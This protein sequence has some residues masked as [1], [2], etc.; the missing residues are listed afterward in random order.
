MNIFDG[1]ILGVIQGLTEFLPV[2]SSGHL[3]LAQELLNVNPPGALI[4]IVLHI[5]TFFSILVFYRVELWELITGFLNRQCEALSLVVNILIG[6][7]PAV[8]GGLLLKPHLEVFFSGSFFTGI[9]LCITG[10]IL[11]LQK[12]R[13]PNDHPIHYRTALMIG[14][15]QMIAILP[16]I[17]RSGMTITAAILLGVSGAVAFRFSFLL[18]LPVIAGAAILSL[19]DVQQIDQQLV[20]SLIPGCL[21]AAITGFAA[22]KILYTLVIEQK[23]WRFSF[24]CWAIGLTGIYI[25]L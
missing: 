15:A 19:S 25:G 18:A 20:L 1:L 21:V 11:F 8:L 13:E 16:G 7:L 5:G 3:V 24:Y 4:E 2:S 14:L 23:M 22:L 12:S 17:S 9:F 6:T 10:C